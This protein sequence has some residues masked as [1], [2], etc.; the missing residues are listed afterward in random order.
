MELI[1][2]IELLQGLLV[3]VVFVVML[4]INFKVWRWNYTVPPR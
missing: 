2:L 4:A 3:L 1:N